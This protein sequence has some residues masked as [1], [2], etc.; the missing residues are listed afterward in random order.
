MRATGPAFVIRPARPGEAASL[1][2]LA[3]RSK[4]HWGYDEA[5]L[6]SIQGLL[7][8]GEADLASDIVWV[9]EH[10]GEPVGF[11]R[12]TGAPPE[13]ELADLWLDPSAIGTGLGRRLAGHALAK[14]SDAGFQTL[15]IESDPNAEGF[16]E[17]LGARRIGER[18][19][20]SG[21]LLPLLRITT[22]T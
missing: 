13:G 17:A 5:F 22:A 9:L 10:D 3:L 20:P 1:S 12:V 4:A 6:D 18:R 11:S 16:Y 14:A 15:L 2:A 7:T 8:L 19:S 21:R